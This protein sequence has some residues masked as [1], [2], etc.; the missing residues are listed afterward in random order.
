MNVLENKI[1]GLIYSSKSYCN[2]IIDNVFVSLRLCIIIIF[3]ILIVLLKTDS[4]LISI[5]FPLLPLLPAPCEL[6]PPQEPLLLCV[7]SDKTKPPRDNDKTCQKRQ[8]KS[9]H[10]EAGHSTQ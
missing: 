9:P 3:K 1:S 2:R 6:P 8:V 4:S 10:I 7:S 5:K